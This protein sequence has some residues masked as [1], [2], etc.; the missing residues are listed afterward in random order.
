MSKSWRTRLLESGL[1]LK[2]KYIRVLKHGPKGHKD[3][4]VM[5]KMRRVF[6]EKVERIRKV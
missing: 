6:K 2:D 5:S 4:N 1:V 3:R